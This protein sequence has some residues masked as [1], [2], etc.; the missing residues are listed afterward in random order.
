MIDNCQHVAF[1]IAI[2]FR[3][4][5]SFSFFEIVVDFGICKVLA[6]RV[7]SIL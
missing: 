3:T 5:R 2:N 7:H 6:E 1:S 4:H